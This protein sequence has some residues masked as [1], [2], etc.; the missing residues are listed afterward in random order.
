MVLLS[1]EIFKNKL[2]C[3]KKVKRHNTNLMK[4]LTFGI[5]LEIHDHPNHKF[6]NIFFFF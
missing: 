4:K 3:K 5:R 2:V 1:I 6:I